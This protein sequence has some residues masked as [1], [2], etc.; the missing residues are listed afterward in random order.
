MSEQ[1]PRTLTLIEKIGA[2]E[3]RSDGCAY[4]VCV[5]SGA[6]ILHGDS[7]AVYN[8][9]PEGYEV[10]GIEC[11]T[12]VLIGETWCAIPWPESGGRLVWIANDMYVTL[13]HI[14]PLGVLAIRP[15]PEPEPLRGEMKVGRATE[16]GESSGVAVL[17]LP[18]SLIGKTIRWE[19][20]KDGGE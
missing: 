10:C 20:V 17:L 13:A 5:R 12:K 15:I 19:V 9:I 18:E 1:K 16:M 11:A 6:G 3:V 7:Y 2:D 4:L 8:P 14:K